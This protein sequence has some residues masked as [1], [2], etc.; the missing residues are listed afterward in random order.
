MLY[1]FFGDIKVI[2]T[3]SF[4]PKSEYNQK[5]LVSILTSICQKYNRNIFSTGGYF[6]LQK[7]FW[8]L[9]AYRCTTYDSN[10][11]YYI[12]YTHF[13][14]YLTSGYSTAPDKITV[15]VSWHTSYH[16]CKKIT[17]LVPRL[18]SLVPWFQKSKIL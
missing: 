12:L 18:W 1:Y 4:I 7:Y 8:Y 16:Q 2:D 5:P 15:I 10:N 13:N 11:I 3:I 17:I 6:V 14:S 9:V